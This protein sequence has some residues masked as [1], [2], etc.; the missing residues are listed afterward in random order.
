[1]VLGHEK[2]D[3]YRLATGYVAW[4]FE[5]SDNLVGEDSV[6]YESTESDFHPDSDPD[7]SERARRSFP[8]RGSLNI[9]HRTIWHAEIWTQ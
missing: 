4:V 2:L 7:L 5:K 6:M 9:Y 1:M 8:E 3:V